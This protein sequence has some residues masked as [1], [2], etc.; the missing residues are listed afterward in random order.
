MKYV[1]PFLVCLVFTFSC[2]TGGGRNRPENME[3]LAD[4]LEEVFAVRADT[5]EQKKQAMLAVSDT[6]C[7]F[8]FSD[9]NELKERDTLAFWLM[10]RLMQTVQ[11]V[12]TADDGWAWM[13]AMNDYVEKC[14]TV[15]GSQISSVESAKRAIEELLMPY[16]GGYQ[17]QMNT[18][19]YV[20]SI[21]E[22]YRT[23]DG[24]L[25]FINAIDDVLLKNLYWQEYQAWFDLNNALNGIMYF[26]TYAAAT[27]SSLSMDI[28]GRFGYWS[29]KRCEE[30]DVESGILLDGESF[31]SDSTAVAEETFDELTRYIGERSESD[32]VGE[33]TADRG[34]SPDD[35]A[36]QRCYDNFDFEKIKEMV[37]LYEI[38][39]DQWC[40]VR[41]DIALTLS[42]KQQKSYREITKQA[43]HRFYNDLLELK[44][45][46]Y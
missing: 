38:A 35:I 30:L 7:N 40:G 46:K 37:K 42:G 25:S 21:L 9:D 26:Y 12:Q 17:M 29:Q 27:Y 11:E 6:E 44:P 19:S 31:K 8:Y 2:C 18:A 41:E 5:I 10:N 32:I 15:P 20:F 43:N 34:L 16:C 33:I 1:V 14:S 39:L 36:Y 45:L 24:Y 22:I 23:T 28:N 13:L 4:S 3:M